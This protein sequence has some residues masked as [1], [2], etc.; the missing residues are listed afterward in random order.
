MYYII[1]TGSLLVVSAILVGCM[2][3]KLS[4]FQD[5]NYRPKLMLIVN[6]HSWG[7]RFL[8][9][10]IRVKKKSWFVSMNNPDSLHYV[11]NSRGLA[12]YG[13]ESGILKF[14]PSQIRNPP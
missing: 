1:S 6:H 8:R 14:R 12:A 9:Q 4:I 7:T 11:Y 3:M 5:F 13:N 2:S 10:M